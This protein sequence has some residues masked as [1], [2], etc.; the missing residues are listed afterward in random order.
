M[1]LSQPWLGTWM[2]QVETGG[3]CREEGRNKDRRGGE[4]KRRRGEKRW[5]KEQEEE[6]GSKRRARTRTRRRE[7]VLRAQSQDF[8][9]APEPVGSVWYRQAFFPVKDG[10]EAR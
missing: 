4:E 8:F 1:R 5:T 9:V 2:G 10:I 6:E 3:C 7:L